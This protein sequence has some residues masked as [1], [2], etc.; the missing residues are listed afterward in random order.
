MRVTGLITI[1][2]NSPHGP[3]THPPMS[4]TAE[5]AVSLLR[6]KKSYHPEAE[7][8]LPVLVRQAR[9]FQTIEYGVLAPEVGVSSPRNLGYPLGAIGQTMLDLGQRWDEKIP[10]IQAIVVNKT[11]GLPG[12][13][14]AHFA[15]DPAVFATATRAEK[16]IIV[17]GML[18]E[19]FTYPDWDRV[20]QALD[21]HSASPPSLPPVDSVAPNVRG[22]VGEGEE[23]LALKRL[24]AQS[25]NLVGAA[26]MKPEIEAR[27]YSGDSVDV[28]FRGRRRMLAVEVKGERSAPNDIL[29][30]LFQCVKYA[31]VL[32]A[33]ARVEG[34][35]MDVEAVL[36][37]GGHLPGDLR[38]IANTLGY[39]VIDQVTAG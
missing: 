30:G 9:A 15:P 3:P 26:G 27:L 37:L 33:Q 11:D 25:P 5:K 29:R 28:L 38:G 36:V 6:G 18:Q 1:Q 21:L 17:R 39:P 16:R 35:R 12:D 8:T 34:A 10:P 2:V 7:R 19:V 23:H 20:L 13:G 14:V 32:E 4:E 22:G 24:V 31:A